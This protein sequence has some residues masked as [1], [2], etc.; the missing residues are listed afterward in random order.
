MVIKV[1]TDEHKITIP[2][3]S[4]LIFN[5]FTAKLISKIDDIP[6]TTDQMNVIMRELRHAKSILKGEPI[7]E[8]H[9]NNGEDVLIKL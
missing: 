7:L 5:G 3:P 8:V 9:S 2:L 1:K 6:L 4:G